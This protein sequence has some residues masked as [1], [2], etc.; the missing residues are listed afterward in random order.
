MKKCIIYARTSTKRQRSIPDQVRVCKEY[1]T[2]NKLTVSNIFSDNGISGAHLKREGYQ[3][4]LK[5]EGHGIV[6]CEDVSRLWRNSAAQNLQIKKWAD[7]GVLLIEVNEDVN[8]E[9]ITERGIINQ[10][11]RD[12]IGKYC[13][14]TLVGKAISGKWTGGNPAYGYRMRYNFVEDEIGQTRRENEGLEIIRHE[15]DV[16]KLIFKRYAEGE[17]TVKICSLLN[18]LGYAT[19]HKKDSWIPTTLNG[20]ALNNT[21]ILNNHIYIGQQIYNKNK[22]IPHPNTSK[23]KVVPN[24]REEWVIFRHDELRIID[25]RTWEI[26]KRI[27]DA[28][29]LV[30]N[31]RIS[32]YTLR[33]IHN[34]L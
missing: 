29:R 25:D 5:A 11:Y 23:R 24:N 15:A 28:K 12:I 21:G 27:Q 33:R 14:R 6:L 32:R 31:H 18:E 16:V 22:S 4:L 34:E 10:K 9:L 3:A 20:S 13:K 1:A 26:V 8:K 30:Q 2:K 19:P 7:Q 17:S